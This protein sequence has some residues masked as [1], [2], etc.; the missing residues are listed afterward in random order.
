MLLVCNDANAAG[1]VLESLEKWN[2]P[3]S[4]QRIER[5]RRRESLDWKSLHASSGWMDA[6]SSV[7]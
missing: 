4:R 2:N 1:Q 6:V 7:A 5:M 3:E